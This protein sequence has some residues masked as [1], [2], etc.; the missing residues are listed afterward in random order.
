MAT[1]LDASTFLDPAE[2]VDFVANVL[3]ASTEY[4]IIGK[5]PEGKIRLLEP[6]LRGRAAAGCPGR[7]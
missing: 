2:A 7:A 5:D 6:F 4:S 3:E 1:L